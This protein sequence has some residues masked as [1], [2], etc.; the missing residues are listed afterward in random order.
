MNVVTVVVVKPVLNGQL[1]ELQDDSVCV[2]FDAP[3]VE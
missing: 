1:G 2:E 3:Q